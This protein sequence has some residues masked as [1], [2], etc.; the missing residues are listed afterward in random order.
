MHFL[1]TGLWFLDIGNKRI[2]KVH[3]F[4]CISFALF[5]EIFKYL[6]KHSFRNTYSPL[7]IAPKLLL[8]Y[9]LWKIHS[10][11]SPAP[12]LWYITQNFD[13][14]VI[15]PNRFTENKPA[16]P[17]T[18]TSGSP[19]GWWTIITLMRSSVIC[20]I[21]FLPCSNYA[22][23]KTYKILHYLQKQFIS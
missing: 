13:R 5:S 1:H 6:L 2:W 10:L 14:L 11:P 15:D 12:H 8:F 17:V 4:K 21:G 20:F 18:G 7:P 19:H 22:L 23:K 3:T 9:F 16:V